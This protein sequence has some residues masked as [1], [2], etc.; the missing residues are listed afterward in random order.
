MT[1]KRIGMLCLLF[2]VV[3]IALGITALPSRADDPS[4]GRGILPALRQVP[5]F[6]RLDEDQLEKLAEI[7]ELTERQAGKRII[8]QGK[9]TRKMF[10]TLDSEVRI[11]INGNLIVVLPV[12]AL[13]GEIEFLEDRPATADVVL[14]TKSRV[15]SMENKSLRKLMD[16]NPGIGYVLMDEIARM[17]AHRLRTTSERQQK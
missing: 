3:F 16:A 15:I 8:A 7:T 10:I 13:V 6:Q 9:R 17:E 12:N 14:I 2:G 4:P 1:V 11:L 5:L